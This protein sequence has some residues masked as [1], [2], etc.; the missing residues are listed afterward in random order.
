[1]VTTECVMEREII[2]E[3]LVLSINDEEPRR[4]QMAMLKAVANLIQCVMKFKE[5]EDFETND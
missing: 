2:N 1:M 3:V 4:Q 5:A